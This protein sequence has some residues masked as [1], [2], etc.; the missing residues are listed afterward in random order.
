MSF[1]SD[2]KDEICKQTGT[3][4]H[5]Q[6]A[7][8]AALFALIGNIKMDR[9][10]EPYLRMHTENLTVAGKSYILLKKIF[11]VEV[12]VSVRN[13]NFHAGTLEYSIVIKRV[14]D[15][16]SILKAVKI[17]DEQNNQWGDFSTVHPLIVQNICCR[18]AFLRGAFLVA[19]SI[20]NPEKAYHLEI[21]VLSEKFAEQIRQIISFFEID[22]KIVDRKSVV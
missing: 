7:E 9:Y 4:R 17:M 13:H 15:V 6:I 8:F 1:S 5:C 22:A 12:D 3:A 20:T 19:G 21:A 10:G 14:K 2:V 11:G 16:I 18:R